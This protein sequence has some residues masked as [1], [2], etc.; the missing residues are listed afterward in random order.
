MCSIWISLHYIFIYW[1][2]FM[3]FEHFDI[4]NWF[5]YN[6]LKRKYYLGICGDFFFLRLI[7][8]VRKYYLKFN[9]VVVMKFSPITTTMHQRRGVR[10]T[11]VATMAVFEWYHP[12]FFFFSPHVT[13]PFFSFCLVQ[14][15][16][17]INI[18]LF[19]T[20]LRWFLKRSEGCINIS[21]KPLTW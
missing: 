8:S 10:A 19:E 12:F 16:T 4:Y 6:L 2:Y 11:S 20:M 5:Y 3:L 21:F 14:Q 9:V 1:W 13:L 7:L 18:H 17:S 15:Y